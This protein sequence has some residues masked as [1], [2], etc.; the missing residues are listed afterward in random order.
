[1]RP[2]NAL[3]CLALAANLVAL[4]ACLEGLRSRKASAR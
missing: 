1:V 3:L 2:F 4:L